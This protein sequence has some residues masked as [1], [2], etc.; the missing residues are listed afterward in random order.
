MVS[1]GGGRVSSPRFRWSKVN[2]STIVKGRL[3]RCTTYRRR[4]ARWQKQLPCLMNTKKKHSPAQKRNRR[5]G[6]KAPRSNTTHPQHSPETETWSTPSETSLSEMQHTKTS[7]K[8]TASQK[9]KTNGTSSRG[10][11]HNIAPQCC[12]SHA[13]IEKRQGDSTRGYCHPIPGFSQ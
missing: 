9:K 5:R 11:W 12:H 3:G 7:Q 10:M 1:P 6:P 2:P 4:T 13:D 8:P